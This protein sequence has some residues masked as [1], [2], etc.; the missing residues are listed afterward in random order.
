MSLLF[1]CAPPDER[2]ELRYQQLISLT[3]PSAKPASNNFFLPIGEYK[4]ELHLF[5][6]VIEVPEHPMMSD[7]EKILPI[8]INEKK[9]QLFPNVSLEFI[10]NNGHLIPIERDIIIPVNTSSYWQIQISPGR[11]WSEKGDNDMSRASFPFLLTSIIEN[12]SYNGI[13]TFLYDD[14]FYFYIIYI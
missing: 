12:E 3:N 2:D 5:S 4:S 8:D 14:D 11:V 1:S 10:S 6:G 9:T 13:A 7:P